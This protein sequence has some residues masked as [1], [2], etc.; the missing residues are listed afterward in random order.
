MWSNSKL[1]CD[2]MSWEDHCLPYLPP[3]LNEKE[4]NYKFLCLGFSS[5]TLAPSLAVR[6][7]A[8]LS[9][10]R[11]VVSPSAEYLSLQSAWHKEWKRAWVHWKLSWLLIH[12]IQ[13]R[14]IQCNHVANLEKLNMISI[15]LFACVVNTS[16]SCYFWKAW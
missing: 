6:M 14:M 1:G 5:I 10:L 7:L 16:E 13:D 2:T 11:R 4:N 8:F 9:E 3:E 15:K 12:K